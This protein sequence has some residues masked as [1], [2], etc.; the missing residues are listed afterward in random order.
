VTIP[1]GDDEIERVRKADERRGRRPT[2]RETIE[3]RRRTIAALREV[4]T[5]GTID[6][7]KDVMRD[8]GFPRIR[9]SGRRLCGFGARSANGVSD[10]LQRQETF[11]SLLLAQTFI[12]P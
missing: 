4:L 1:D 10:S 8:T 6:T 9:P 2:D 7:L 12:L 11:L 3:E 5:D